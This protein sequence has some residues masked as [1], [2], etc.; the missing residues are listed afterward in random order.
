MKIT[1]VDKTLKCTCCGCTRFTIELPGDVTVEDVISK[2][3]A[4]RECDLQCTD[5]GRLF[6]N[7]QPYG[8]CG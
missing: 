5:C 8:G 1:L 4:L 2:G 7:M 3:T 6:I